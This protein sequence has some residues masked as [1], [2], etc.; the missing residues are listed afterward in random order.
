MTPSRFFP[1]RWT[2]LGPGARSGDRHRARQRAV[3]EGLVPRQIELVG[4]D[5]QRLEVD[6][7]ARVAVVRRVRDDEGVGADGGAAQNL[8]RVDAEADL[9][10]AAGVPG[11][12]GVAGRVA[13]DAVDVPRWA[14]RGGGVRARGHEDR[15]A[16]GGAATAPA[17]DLRSTRLRGVRRG[18]RHRESRQQATCHL[19]SPPP[20]GL[21]QAGPAKVKKK[22]AL[23]RRHFRGP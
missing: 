12:V 9:D 15:D 8:G 3:V 2:P 14:R 19:R 7:E 22:R 21:W 4:A 17:D 11:P 13:V 23:P 5:L 18:E 6:V 1:R 16:V 10:H 20:G